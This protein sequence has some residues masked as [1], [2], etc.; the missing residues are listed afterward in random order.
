MGDDGE[1][2]AKPRR[3]REAGR[4][5]PPFRAAPR[6]TT[7]A[8]VIPLSAELR[9]YRLPF[10]RRDIP[11]G[12]TV[13][14][15]AVPSAMA[16]AELAGLSPVA[17]LYALLLPTLAYALLGSSK[18]LIVGPEGSVSALIAAT[19]LGFAAA[20]SEEAA[21]IAATLALLVGACCLITLVLR[22]GWIANYFS[23]PVLVG[24]I[25]GV[26][27]V[28][29]VSQVPKLLGIDVEA[30]DPVP[31]LA[32]IFRE[33]GDI[34]PA[35]A[36]V[37]LVSLAVL[38]VARYR[39]PRLP[40]PLFV[41][42]AGILISQA[43]DLASYGVAVVGEIPSG[44][45]SPSLPSPGWETVV[46][47]FPAAVGLFLVSFAD[48]I[49]TAR[50]YARGPDEHIDTHAEL[51][52][53]GAAQASAGI[54]QAF[55]IGAS[56]SRTAVN[57]AMGARSQV[58]ALVAAVAV[59]GILLFLTGPVA[60]LPKT[61]LAAAI[62]SAALGLIDPAAWRSLAAID[63]VEVA[64]AGVTVA[65]VVVLGVLE[66]VSLA[67]ALSVVDVVRRSATPRDAVLGWVEEL[68]RWAD[69]TDY[70]DARLIDGVVVYRIEDRLFF[71][72]AG[73]MS[74]RV[75]EAVRGAN[76]PVRWVVLDAGAVSHVDATG[77]E[78]LGELT[79]TLAEEGV[80]LV[81]AHMLS[82]VRQELEDGGLVERIGAD[83]FHGT[84]RAAVAACVQA[85]A[86]E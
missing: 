66:A 12:A 52:A 40:A 38:L 36:V 68:G 27:I 85:D 73:Y 18:K 53:M 51:R 45:P 33:L 82:A 20:G 79:A 50:A 6:G 65:G 46:E 13:A 58:A 59:V 81:V 75:R 42:I 48:E 5:E 56:G 37:G 60:E 54:T 22:L 80:T 24:Y 84:V 86:P 83:N 69:V 77:L 62:I 25:H 32:E 17:G 64:I 74:R 71:A 21:V 57:D 31:Q 19:V 11:A 2:P 9:T 34:V 23:R 35:T 76:A 63:R 39:A 47:L 72:N 15:L 10:A 8:R 41:V 30:S 3:D 78:V 26:S 14:A 28:L 1:H 49:L 55:P 29:I 67:V 4:R 43:F 16:Y 61:V 7:L 44:L 70:P